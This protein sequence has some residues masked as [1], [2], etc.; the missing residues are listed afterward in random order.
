MP[1]YEYVCLDC[2]DQFDVL[3]SMSMADEPINCHMCN[4]D[5]TSRMLSV[6]YAQSGGKVVAGGNNQG[7][8]ACSSKACST[9]GI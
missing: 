9:C 5:H 7:C 3:R 8:A 2:G 6:F 4:S 1:I